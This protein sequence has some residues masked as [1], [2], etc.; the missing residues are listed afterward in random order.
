VP[1]LPP[2]LFRNVSFVAGITVGSL[3]FAA[4]SG[5][6]YV[7]SLFLQ[8]GEQLSPFATAATMAPLSVGIIVTAFAFRS[9]VERL[10][11]RLVAAGVVVTLLGVSTYLALTITG[12]ARP[13][14]L[15]LPLLC[16][17]LGMGCC[18]GSLFATAL[19]DVDQE[20]AGSASGTLNALQQVAN[21][22]GAALVST[23]FLAVVKDQGAPAAATAS[24]TAVLVVLVLCGAC[25]PLLPRKAA[26]DHH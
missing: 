21:A 1:L 19:G 9:R 18:V 26:A 2:A 15:T 7:T 24:L 10:G 23:V 17:G 25:V 14:L 22:V 4:V 3:F 5:L 16:V 6:L 20:Q 11:R 13:A 8:E 12:A